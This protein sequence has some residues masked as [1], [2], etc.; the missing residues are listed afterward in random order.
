M[1]YY[2]VLSYN[3]LISWKYQINLLRVFHSIRFKVNK[4]WS[5][6]R[7]AFFFAHQSPRHSIHVFGPKYSFRLR[8]GSDIEKYL[9]KN[10]YCLNI[11]N[12]FVRANKK[13]NEQHKEVHSYVWFLLLTLITETNNIGIF[14]SL[15]SQVNQVLIL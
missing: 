8:K 15:L 13:F 10:L 3:V 4:D 11:T 14:S 2:I 6:V 12:I 9:P 7:V 5:L 1:L